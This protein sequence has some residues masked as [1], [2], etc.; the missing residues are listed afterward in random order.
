MESPISEIEVSLLSKI[1]WLG[2]ET[3]LLYL[4]QAGWVWEIK[5]AHFSNALQNNYLYI[6]HPDH[7]LIGRAKIT[8]SVV[9]L[10][11]WS[12]DALDFLTHEKN[13]RI[14]K[15]IYQTEE[16]VTIPLKEFQ[17]IKQD[18]TEDDISPMLEAILKIQAN[19]PRR[20]IE[21]PEAEILEFMRGR[22][23]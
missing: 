19:R 14:A 20:R 13:Q 9:L 2:W 12:I 4:Q 23:F 18:L 8:K 21:L 11:L 15:K 10:N 3:N 7:K 17:Y 22:V 1:R 5:T 6:R 16:V